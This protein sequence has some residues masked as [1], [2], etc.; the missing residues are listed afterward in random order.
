MAVEELG[1]KAYGSREEL[2][3]DKWCNTNGVK[4]AGTMEIEA[5]SD[6]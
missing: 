1:G 2:R 3:S 4:K 5:K 6:T